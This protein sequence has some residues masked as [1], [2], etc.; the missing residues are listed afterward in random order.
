MSYENTK[1]PCGGKKPTETML[2]ADC[3]NAVA[4]TYD[5]VL[6]D[7]PNAGFG[8]RRRSAIRVLSVARRRQWQTHTKTVRGSYVPPPNAMPPPAP[9]FQ[10]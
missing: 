1:C 6:M 4:G 2:C 10:P 8:D 9:H 5:R 3:E 7:N